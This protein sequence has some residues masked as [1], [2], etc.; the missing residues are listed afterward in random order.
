MQQSEFPWQATSPVTGEVAIANIYNNFLNNLLKTGRGVQAEDLLITIGALTGF[1]AQR[2]ALYRAAAETVVHGHVSTAN[3]LAKAA[4]E[5]GYFLLGD[6]INQYLFPEGAFGLWRFLAA[7]A[8][9]AGTAPEALPD[10][11]DIARVVAL[12]L[13][14][15]GFG[16]L[17]APKEHL[18]NLKPG[19]AVRLF[20]KP[21][22]KIF[23]LPAPPRMTAK[24][25]PLE[26]AH[27]PVVLSLVAAKFMALTKGNLDPALAFS[28]VLE[29]AVV[30]SKIAPDLVAGEQ[31]DVVARDGQLQ[32]T[33]LRMQ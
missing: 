30:A 31:W 19:D 23:N 22:C 5:G 33:R 2:A 18:G 20:W 14:G 27:W 26:P 1:A 29:S 13:G 17:H 28:L 15:P 24:E 32:V 4:F 16:V 21:L 9:E 7:V 8:Q 10:Y 25:P 6:G 12:S 11:K 3:S